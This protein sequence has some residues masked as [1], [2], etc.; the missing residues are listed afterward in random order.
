MSYFPSLGA[1]ISGESGIPG[2]HTSVWF[3]MW[4]PTNMPSALVSKIHADVSAV[5]DLPQTSEFFAKN[6]F[7]RVDGSPAQFA[8]LIENDLKHWEAVIKAVG[9]KIE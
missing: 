6:S 3:G 8:S 4:G 2:F 5:L 1:S 7:S 9:I